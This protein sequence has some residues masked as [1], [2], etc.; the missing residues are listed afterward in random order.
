[1]GLKLLR[2]YLLFEN[3]MKSVDFSIREMH[4]HT[5]IQIRVYFQVGFVGPLETQTWSQ[6]KCPS[7]T[8][9]RPTLWT[10]NILSSV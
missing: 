10:F 9:Q 6:V 8:R 5:Y 4:L 1:M 2:V 3:Q 7:S